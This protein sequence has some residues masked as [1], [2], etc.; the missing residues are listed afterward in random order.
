M[1]M[2]EFVEHLKDKDKKQVEDPV[3]T[4]SSQQPPPPPPGPAPAIHEKSGLE[5]QDRKNLQ[6]QL[7]EHNL[8]AEKI[9]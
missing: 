4:G 8:L 9:H 1:S 7:Q 3:V 2:A 6:L 5:A